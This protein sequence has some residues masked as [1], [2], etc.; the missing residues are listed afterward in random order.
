SDL[1]LASVRD[2]KAIIRKLK[3][4]K[5]P[6]PD[7]IHNFVLKNLPLKAVIL[8]TRI[9]NKMI[10]LS[11]FPDEWKCAKVTPILKP[12]K[13]PG[14]TSSYRPI[15]LLNTL[16]KI[17]EKVILAKINNHIDA[18]ELLPDTQFGFRKDHSSI[19][20][21]ALLIEKTRS[22]LPDKM[23]GLVLLDVEKAFD[24]MW[25]PG[26]LYKL[27]N[28]NFPRHIILL[29][30]SYLANRSFYVSINNEHSALM[31][32]AA[33]VPQGSIL[34]PILYILYISDVPR[35]RHSDLYTYADDMALTVQHKSLHHILFHLQLHLDLI[36]DYC[37]VWRI[38]L[39]S[40]KSE[41]IIFSRHLHKTKA[42]IPLKLN[43]TELPWVTQATYLGVILDQKLNLAAHINRRTSLATAMLHL[44]QPLLKYNSGLNVQNK[45]RI[46]LAFVR[47]ILTYGAPCL[48][49]IAKKLIYALQLLQNKILRQLYP[50]EA[51]DARGYYTSTAVLHELARIPTIKE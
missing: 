35:T 14:Q 28:Y 4:R 44:L 27:I 31:P 16:S 6:G 43:N 13:P 37:E 7:G 50:D 9:I 18:H 48:N 29:M 42:K 21:P 20:P 32:I 40:N 24:T 8:I 39:N 45:R 1:G 10:Q 23:A 12:K 36:T 33:G 47:P 11:H 49:D 19:H 51:K 46:F 30:N 25:I 2:I 26:L 38:R 3:T 22:G 5:S 41:A 34:G 17:A 15:S